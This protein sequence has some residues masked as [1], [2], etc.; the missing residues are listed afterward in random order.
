MTATAE[1]P[2]IQPRSEE[3]ALPGLWSGAPWGQEQSDWG[4]Q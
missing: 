4:A 2:F 1:K 3:P